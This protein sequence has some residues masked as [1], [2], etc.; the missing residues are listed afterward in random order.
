MKEK[1][2][3]LRT[4]CLLS[5]VVLM[6]SLVL[7]VPMQKA[8]ASVVDLLQ[9]YWVTNNGCAGMNHAGTTWHAQTFTANSTYNLTAIE[10]QFI[11]HSGA[12]GSLTVSI[13][14]TDGSGYPTGPDLAISNPASVDGLT[15]DACST[16]YFDFNSPFLELSNGV[17]YAIVART[18]VGSGIVGIGY[19]NPGGYVPGEAFQSFNAGVG[20]LYPDNEP[21]SDLL[22]RIY[23]EGTV[24]PSEKEP[25]VEVGGDI[26]PVN[27]LAVM[28]PWLALSAVIL[29]GTV[30][31]ARR[32]RA[33][34]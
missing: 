18:F 19:H 16:V 28:A 24:P 7:M 4:V 31:A 13:R 22:F 2:I 34:N 15:V 26:Y 30:M 29:A 21:T 27:K 33:R 14:N 6:L 8:K 20:W 1:S 32:Y 23:G 11:R 12:T 25:P 5:I 3:K 10:L 17:K 9:E